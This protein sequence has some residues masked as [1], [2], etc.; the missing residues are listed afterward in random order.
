MRKVNIMKLLDLSLS[1]MLKHKVVLEQNY[2]FN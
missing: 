2:S 1:L